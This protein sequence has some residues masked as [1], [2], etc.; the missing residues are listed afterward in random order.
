MRYA[1]P[2][3][4]EEWAVRAASRHTGCDVACQGSRAAGQ[5]VQTF[6]R[7]VCWWRGT[8]RS[9]LVMAHRPSPPHAGGRLTVQEVGMPAAIIHSASR[10][11]TSGRPD[12]PA[13]A[14][15]MDESNVRGAR[16]TEIARSNGRHPPTGP[17]A[18]P[19]REPA[20]KR[21]SSSSLTYRLCPW[22]PYPKSTV[23]D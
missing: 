6:S 3:R 13:P 8:R 12:E 7:V 16:P 22:P 20:N 4:A 2:L 14:K 18:S 10:W 19:T 17:L 5:R 1:T 23:I 15:P 21:P 9:A 11:V